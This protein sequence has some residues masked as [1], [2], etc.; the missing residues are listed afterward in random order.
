MLHVENGQLI[1]AQQEEVI[2]RGVNLGGWLLQET[3]MCP[4]TGSESNSQTIEILTT[5]FGEEK[6]SALLKSYA[7]NYITQKDLQILSSLGCNCVRVPF[8]YRNFMDENYQFYS[9]NPDEIY[10]FQL[11]DRLIEICQE[12]GIYIILDLHGAPGGQSSDHST[13]AVGSCLLYSDEQAQEATVQLWTAIAQR[14]QDCSVIAAYDLLN[15]PMNNDTST[16]PSLPAAG[17][18]EAIA[19]TWKIYDLLYQAIR[20]VDQQHPI[21]VEGIWST[22]CLPDP[23]LYGWEN[24]IYELHLYDSQKEMIDYRISELTTVQKK[25]G[26]AVFVGEFNN[27]DQNQSYAYQ[28]YKKAKLSFTMWNYK[29]GKGN[30]GNWGLY[31]SSDSIVD[32]LN[33]SYEEILE[34]WG[35]TLQTENYTL[36]QTV[37]A[38][39][40]RGMK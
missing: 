20:T 21:A 35:K 1:N 31:S 30:L 26:V 36:N 34:K 23:S 16:Y 6:A 10:G 37:E 39:I 9:E 4:L 19:Q 3:W 40:K 32:L 24:M 15:E 8:W 7:E 13:G 5:R 33:D 11:L 28:K 18:S 2:L 38:W 27:G 17:S 22:D 29:V 25:Y 14:Y 12:E